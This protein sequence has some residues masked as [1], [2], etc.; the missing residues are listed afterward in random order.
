MI[1]SKPWA[2]SL[3]LNASVKAPPEPSLVAADD[4]DAARHE[5]DG[6][7]HAGLLLKVLAGCRSVALRWLVLETGLILDRTLWTG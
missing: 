5:V 1:S 6:Q 4:P 7:I 3:S 2:S